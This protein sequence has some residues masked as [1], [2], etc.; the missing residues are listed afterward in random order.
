MCLLIGV[1]FTLIC[2]LIFIH[3]GWITEWNFLTCWQ[4][5]C[6]WSFEGR[7]LRGSSQS[8]AIVL[9]QWPKSCLTI[10]VWASWFSTESTNRPCLPRRNC[11]RLNSCHSRWSRRDSSDSSP[12]FATW[13]TSRSIGRALQ[14]ILLRREARNVVLQNDPRTSYKLWSDRRRWGQC[15]LLRCKSTSQAGS[16]GARRGKSHT[17]FPCSESGRKRRAR[18]DCRTQCCFCEFQ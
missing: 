11:T 18:R 1:C 15:R 17:K 14:G 16:F 7:E 2:N 9:G 5:I 10:P 3:L 12:T 13:R 8:W 4:R 6:T